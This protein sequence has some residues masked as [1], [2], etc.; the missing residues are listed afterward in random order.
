MKNYINTLR[1]NAKNDI[2]FNALTKEIPLW[3]TEMFDG[4]ANMQ[5]NNFTVSFGDN[6]YKTMRV[7]ELVQNSKV[8]WYVENSLIAVPELINQTEW[9]GTSIVWQITSEENNTELQLTHI[10][11]NVNIECYDICTRGWKQFTDSLKQFVET[12]EGKPFKR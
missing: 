9:I 5:G 10:G 7:V 8:L 1:L 4:S 3:W 11:L 12:G 6:V 2:V